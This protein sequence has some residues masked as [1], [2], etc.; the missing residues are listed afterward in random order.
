MQEFFL[1]ILFILE[2]LIF[3]SVVFLQMVKES[4]S[5]VFLYACQS[6]TVA[7]MLV[8]FSYQESSWGL[9]IT[10]AVMLLVKVVVAPI[11]FNRLI[12]SQKIKFSTSTYLN[13]PLTLLVIMFIMMLVNSSVFVPLVSLAYETQQVVSVALSTILASLFLTINRRGALSQII[14]I[15]SLENSIVSFASLIGLKQT[16]GLELGII[17]DIFVWIVIAAVFM[18]MMYK[19]FGSL[20]I[21]E[22]KTLK[23]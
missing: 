10:A 9:L 17:F 18:S 5:V 19:H 12:E 14:G 4:K 6:L 23:D 8:I 1:Q 13:T 20:N 16:I 3:L 2:V 22:I 15:L 21:T 11:F 7:A